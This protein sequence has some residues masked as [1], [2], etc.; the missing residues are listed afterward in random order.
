[1][2]PHFRPASSFSLD[3][4][5]EL[6]T[7]TFAN[8]FYEAIVTPQDMA[9]YCRIEQIDLYYSPVMCVGA[10]LVGLATVGL[11]G[12]AAYCK[13]FGVI[14]PYRGQGLSLDLSLEV[15][16]QSRLVGARHLSL[17]VMQQNERAVKTYQHAG[18]KIA[19]ALWSFEWKQNSTS[20]LTPLLQREGNVRVVEPRML[21]NHFAALHVHRPTWSRDLPSLLALTDAEGLALFDGD[22]L[23]AY[24]LYQRSGT[25][26]DIGATETAHVTALLRALQQQCTQIVCNNEPAD[27]PAIA[28]LRELGFNKTI[29]RYEMTMEL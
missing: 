22:K 11:R 8:Y 27:S 2:T 10:E 13:G 15:I 3:A 12:E 18:M 1:M 9:S 23:M 14:V 7:K 29:K 4:T 21:L 5:A 19:R 24:L 6:Y 16:R 20:P 17:G 28:A 26:V 25:I